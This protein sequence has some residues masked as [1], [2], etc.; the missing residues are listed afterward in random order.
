MAWLWIW[1][2]SGFLFNAV[3]AFCGVLALSVLL[4]RNSCVPHDFARISNAYV[5]YPQVLLVLSSKWRCAGERCMGITTG[6]SEPWSIRVFQAWSVYMSW[7]VILGL[8]MDAFGSNK[9]YIS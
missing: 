3:E 1:P 9:I 4:F 8:Y 2:A 6:I 7:A 5:H